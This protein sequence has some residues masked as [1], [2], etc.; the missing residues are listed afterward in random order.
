MCNSAGKDLNLDLEISQTRCGLHG[1]H[2]L[3]ESVHNWFWSFKSFDDNLI[4][5]VV[6]SQCFSHH[7]SF[8]VMF[9]IL[10]AF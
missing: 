3:V 8:Y 10:T 5:V 2:L 6:P 7:C 1:Q 9:V 4:I